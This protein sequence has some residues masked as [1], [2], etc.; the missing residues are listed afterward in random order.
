[1]PSLQSKAYN[2]IR[3][4][5]QGIGFTHKLLGRSASREQKGANVPKVYNAVE[6]SL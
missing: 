2:A 5:H 3:G 1:M 4:F 6:Q